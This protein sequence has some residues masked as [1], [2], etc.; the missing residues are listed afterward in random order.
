MTDLSTHHG[1]GGDSLPVA[2]TLTEARRFLKDGVVPSCVLTTI[3]KDMGKEVAKLLQSNKELPEMFN[4]VRVVESSP[5][6]AERLAECYRQQWADDRTLL[7]LVCEKKGRHSDQSIPMT[8]TLTPADMAAYLDDP[9]T[10]VAEIPDAHT[11]DDIP[12]AFFVLQHPGNDP[13]KFVQHIEGG[14]YQPKD[15]LLAGDV[16]DLWDEYQSHLRDGNLVYIAEFVSGA[17]MNASLALLAALDVRV[18]QNLEKQRGRPFQGL[19]GRCLQRAKIGEHTNKAGNGRIKQLNANLHMQIL[20]DLPPKDRLLK[21]PEAVARQYLTAS[22]IGNMEQAAGDIYAEAQLTFALH[23]GRLNE[24][25]SS[26]YGLDAFQK[27]TA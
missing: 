24:F 27:T 17:N 2:L 16:S 10:I 4:R 5:R 14:Q 20:A 12:L 23:Y 15:L 1:P 6:N 13:K 3:G 9:H 8:E 25:R 19:M 21:V 26:L 22:E 11:P 7:Q 18:I